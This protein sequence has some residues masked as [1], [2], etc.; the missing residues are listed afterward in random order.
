MEYT[1]NYV[2][3]STTSIDEFTTKVNK[4]LKSSWQFMPG[5]KL[6]ITRVHAMAGL[7]KRF[8]YTRE[9]TKTVTLG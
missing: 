2:M 7:D 3:V 6:I 1:T 9:L 4:L 8:M 5:T